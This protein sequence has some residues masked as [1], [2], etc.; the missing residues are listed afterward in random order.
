[1]EVDGEHGAVASVH[2]FAKDD[3]QALRIFKRIF[4]SIAEGNKQWGSIKVIAFSNYPKLEKFW[5]GFAVF[6]FD[7]F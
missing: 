6:Y 4:P 7:G 5:K 1:V 2:L 3:A